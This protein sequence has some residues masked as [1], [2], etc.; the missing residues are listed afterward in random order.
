MD[1]P[2]LLLLISTIVA[3]SFSNIFKKFFKFKAPFTFSTFSLPFALLFF[4]VVFFVQNGFTINI[5][6]GLLRY[7]IPFAFCFCLSGIFSFLAIKEGDLSLS[8]LFISFSLILPTIYGL[9]FL[10][11]SPTIFF[12][13]GMAFFIACLILTNIKVRN[14]NDQR[15]PITLK[16]VIYI[17][18][19]SIT[20]GV[21]PI[22]QTAQQKE[23]GAKY[24]SEMM[25]VA[26]FIV[27]IVYFIL[28]LTS[29][30]KEKKKA[31][32]SA[33]LFGA[34]SGICVGFVNFMVIYFSGNALIPLSIFF[35]LLS[36]G[37]LLITFAFGY[38]AFKEKYTLI[39]YAGIACGLISVVL[40]NI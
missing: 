27:F 29:K 35:P 38:F 23:Y 12:I 20:N 28:T 10:N 8:G 37:S 9:I 6:H 25:I 24:G 34:L 14:E 17:L 30:T 26:L 22:I 16:W 7:S 39:Q 1:L 31:A 2:T 13:I 11:E 4:I 5:V 3:L 21:S 19:A 32:P 18:I 15:K 33:L 40:L 36:G